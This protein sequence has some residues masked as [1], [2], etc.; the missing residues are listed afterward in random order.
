MMVGQQFIPPLNIFLTCC[1]WWLTRTPAV[2]EVAQAASW[3]ESG[4]VGDWC[5]GNVTVA[6]RNAVSGFRQGLYEAHD[7]RRKE[8][9]NSSGK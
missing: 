5:G 4:G 6:L 3:M 9:K 2:S 8:N 7:E 1:P